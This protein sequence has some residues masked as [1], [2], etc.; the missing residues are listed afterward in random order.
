M[1]HFESAVFMG[2]EESLEEGLELARDGGH[3]DWWDE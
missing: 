2:A 1:L 3:E